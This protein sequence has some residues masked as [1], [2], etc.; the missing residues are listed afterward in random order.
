METPFTLQEILS[1]IHDLPKNKVRG[2]AILP[3]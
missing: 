2:L 3:I 1:A